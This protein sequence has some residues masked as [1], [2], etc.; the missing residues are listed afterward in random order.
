MFVRKTPS[1][2]IK[3]KGALKDDVKS[4]NSRSFIKMKLASLNCHPPPDR[5]IFQARDD[6]GSLR[7]FLPRR[8]HAESGFPLRRFVRQGLLLVW[9]WYQLFLW[10]PPTYK[11]I[12]RGNGR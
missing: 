2:L 10:Y 12:M 3:V 4:Q 11:S 6:S 8:R 7:S 5:G 1:E 9:G